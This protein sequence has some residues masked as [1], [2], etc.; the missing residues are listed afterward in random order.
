MP[1][2]CHEA[3]AVMPY[4]VTEEGE[5]EGCA[6]YATVKEDGEI[7]GCHDTK[8]AAIDQMIALSIAEDLEPGGDYSNRAAPDALIVGDFVSWTRPG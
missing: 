1:S 6:G 3:G 8:Q 7:L 5:L 4:F 2:R